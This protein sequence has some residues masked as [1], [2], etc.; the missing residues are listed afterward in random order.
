MDFTS[1]PS[2]SISESFLLTGKVSSLGGVS[3][4]LCLSHNEGPDIKSFVSMF[5]LPTVEDH[6]HRFF[7]CPCLRCL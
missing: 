4:F 1:S 5:H 7:R 3:V 6:F 2:A